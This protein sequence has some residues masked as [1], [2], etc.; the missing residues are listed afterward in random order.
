MSVP[1]TGSARRLDIGKVLTDGLGVLSQ[2][3][4]PLF[5][6]TLLLQGVPSAVAAWGQ[7]VGWAH[8]LGGVFAAIGGLASL[9]TV[10]MLTGA[11]IY[12]SM[13]AL[14]G[15][16]VDMG[17]CF[18]AGTRRWLPMLGL[19]IGSGLLIAFGF[20]LLFVPGVLLALRWSVAG[21]ALVLEG[22]GIP[23]AMGRSADLTR[24]RRWS[25]FLLFLIYLGIQF[26]LQAALSAVGVGYR[27]AGMTFGIGFPFGDGGPKP[28]LVILLTPI[29][30]VVTT[31]VLNAIATALFREL[32]G[33]K[34]G[35][36][37]EVL[38]EVFA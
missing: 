19:M 5:L 24:D 18:Q 4:G 12:G 3:F 27:A 2:N 10:P 13:R 16:P 14:E 21:P 17:E 31:L 15:R 35:G 8:P 7:V 11:L 26:V 34:E 30:S 33:D 29:I 37:P 6:L 38:G 25:I 20:I 28:A 32:R 1:A 36:N 23:E 22:R 9:V